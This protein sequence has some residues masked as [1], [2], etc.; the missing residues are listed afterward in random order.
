MPTAAQ[1]QLLW[2]KH[3]IH[4]VIL[5]H[6][7]ALDRFDAVL[8]ES[9]YHDDGVDH[10]G[11]VPKTGAE[12]TQF[13]FGIQQN[14]KYRL[15]RHHLTNILIDV[16]GDVAHTETYFTGIHRY[17]RDGQEVELTQYGRYLDLFE[18]RRGVWKIAK[19]WRVRD[20]ARLE[21]VIEDPQPPVPWYMG[22]RSTDDWVYTVFE[23][24][25]KARS[26]EA[27]ARRP[28]AKTRGSKVKS[29]RR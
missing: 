24:D 4:D 27:K 1:L 12:Y 20:F 10:R 18:R 22:R 17:V 16:D 9:L 2:D 25:A 5:R 26:A 23:R 11:D 28:V 8:L 3:A 7:R 15:T 13:V 29:S 14:G 19:R 21:P 6:A